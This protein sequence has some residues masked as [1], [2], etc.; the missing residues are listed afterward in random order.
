MRFLNPM[1]VPFLSRDTTGVVI[2]RASRV[3][4]S[5]AAQISAVGRHPDRW[6]G[7]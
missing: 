5:F 1:I 7:A 4:R 2:L 6:S 3:S